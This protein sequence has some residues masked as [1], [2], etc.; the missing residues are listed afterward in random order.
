MSLVGK[1][2]V[3][4]LFV[5]SELFRYPLRLSVISGNLSKS[6]FFERGGSLSANIW[7]GRG[8]FPA[9]L[10]GVKRLEISLFCMVLRYWQTIISFCH[11]TLIWQSDIR[12]D[13]RTEKQNCDSNTVRC[14]TCSR[15]VKMLRNQLYKYLGSK[16]FLCKETSSCSVIYVF[17]TL[18]NF[19][20]E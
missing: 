7:G 20:P 19:K 5:I 4:F 12:T 10:V 18:V 14:I 11:N 16:N 15:T 8:Q 2:V 6:A 3:D 13:E 1:L 9:A 17:N